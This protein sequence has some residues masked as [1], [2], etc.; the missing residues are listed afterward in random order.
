MNSVCV[1]M[2]P[3]HVKSSKLCLRVSFCPQEKQK[4]LLEVMCG[5]VSERTKRLCSRS[6][7]CPQHSEDQRREIRV[8][9]CAPSDTSASP[10]A[11]RK[12][13]HHSVDDD[14]LGKAGW[15]AGTGLK[16]FIKTAC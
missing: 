9:L 8:Q 7:N 1:H 6:V 5:V 13:T 12:S 10:A 4:Q 14:S 11:K 2:H 15:E 16:A 3:L